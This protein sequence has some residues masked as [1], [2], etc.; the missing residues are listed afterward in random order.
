MG[1]SNWHK[2]RHKK[3]PMHIKNLVIY[4]QNQDKKQ[5][6]SNETLLKQ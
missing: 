2:E 3:T 1:A 6:V 5:E 4:C